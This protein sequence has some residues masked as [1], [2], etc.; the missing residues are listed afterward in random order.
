MIFDKN[1]IF[2]KGIAILTVV[3]ITFEIVFPT[4][5]FSQS[6]PT[7][8]ESTGYNHSSGGENVD[9]FTGDFNYSIPVMDIE[10][11]PLILSYNS[12]VT[13]NQES[14]W[15]GYGW[16]LN[17][18]SIARQMRGV[19]DEFNGDDKI[20]REFTRKPSKIDG[21]KGGVE[22]SAG[23]SV[24][25]PGLPL[26]AQGSIGLSFLKGRYYNNYKGSGKTYDFG[27][28]PNIGMGI[29]LQAGAIPLHVGA[30]VGVGL[31]FSFDTQNGIGVNPSFSFGV[32]GSASIFSAG[33][34]G[35]S[36]SNINTREGQKAKT[37]YSSVTLGILGFSRTRTSSSIKTFG[38][39]TYVPR[40]NFDS[41]GV[42]QVSRKGG[43]LYV[44]AT[45]F[46]VGASA[47]IN[48]IKE[49]YNSQTQSVE[50]SKEIPV[51]GYNNLE[52][53]E[54]DPEGILDFN[55]E[56]ERIFSEKMQTLPFSNITYDL[57]QINTPGVSAMF[58]A[59]R[60]DV[61][62]LSNATVT[63]KSISSSK[64]SSKSF[65]VWVKKVEGN[66]FGIG[67][68]KSGDWEN[69]NGVDPLNFEQNNQILG[70]EKFHFK[71]VGEKTPT[72][73][74]LFNAYGGSNPIFLDMDYD[75][76]NKILN[77]SDTIK[78]P[79]GQNLPPF[80][81]TV[82]QKTEREIRATAINY[83]HNYEL[84]YMNASEIRNY[85]LYEE[86]SNGLVGY[87]VLNDDYRKDH[88]LGKME[89]STP[90]GSV[91]GYGIPAYNLSESEVS[92]NV[93]PGIGGVNSNTG[94][95]NYQHQG[96]ADNSLLNE[97][98]RDHYYDKTTTPAY[99]YSYLLTDIKSSDY[100][101][102]NDDGF[103]PDDI[104]SYVKFNYSR[105]YG[106]TVPFKWRFPVS[107]K[108]TSV[109]GYPQ[110]NFHTGFE[111]DELDDKG[112]YSY[113]EK[114]IWYPNSIETKNYIIEF[115]L[116]DRE[117]AYP[118][119]GKNGELDLNKASKLLR[120]IVLYSREDRLKNGVNATPIKT[121]E[122]EYDYSLCKNNPSNKNIGNSYESSGKLTLKSIRFTSGDSK[123]TAQSPYVFTYENKNPDFNYLDVDR[124]SNY[125]QNDIQKPNLNFPYSIQNQSQADDNIKAWKLKRIVYPT[126][127]GMEVDY[128]ADTY[129]NIQDKG[130]MRHYDMVGVSNFGDLIDRLYNSPGDNYNTSGLGLNLSQ[131]FR[132]PTKKKIPNNV[133][134]FKL[135]EPIVSASRFSANI[136]LRN[137]YFTY[138]EN[139]QFHEMDELYYRTKVSIQQDDLK[140][141]FIPGFAG[142][143]SEVTKTNEHKENYRRHKSDINNYTSNSFSSLDGIGVVGGDNGTYY[144]GYIVLETVGVKD[145]IE[146]K[147]FVNK[148]YQVNP[149]QKNAWNFVR[150]NMPWHIYAKCEDSNGNP[151]IE[152]CD[153]GLGADWKT[154]FTGKINKVLN[155]NEYCLDF[156]PLLSTIRLMD[157][158]GYKYGGNGRIKSITYFDSWNQI[159]G[160]LN[161]ASYTLEYDYKDHLYSVNGVDRFTSG[162]AAYEPI[163]GGDENIYFQPSY[164]DI[165]NR[166]KPDERHYQI[167]PLGESVFPAPTVGYS[168][169]TVKFKDLANLTRNSTG[170]SRYNY[171]TYRNFPV[172]VKKSKLEIYDPGLE[173]DV[174]FTQKVFGVSQGFVVELNDMH[175]KVRNIKV[176]D[177]NDQEVSKTDY[178][179]YNFNDKQKVINEKGEIEEHWLGKEFDIYADKKY[180]VQLNVDMMVTTTKEYALIPIP[181][182]NHSISANVIATGFFA[183]TFQKVINHTAIVKEIK[184]TYLGQKSNQKVVA[185]DKYTG[186]PIVT[187][188]KNEFG[189]D[190]Y[191]V[192]YPSQWRYNS[193]QSKYKNQRF[194][195]LNVTIDAN[196]NLIGT[197]NVEDYYLPGDQ[198]L[199]LDLTNQSQ[200][201][202]FV[203]SVNIAN[204]TVELMNNLG[205][206]ISA[207]SS[208]LLVQVL[209]SAYKNRL[210]ESM[211]S[212]YTKNDPVSN[213][214]SNLT[215]D[216]A[217]VIQ[218]SSVEY[219]ENN[220]RITEDEFGCTGINNANFNCAEDLSNPFKL[221]IIGNWR[222]AKMFAYQSERVNG[223]AVNY[224]NIRND[225]FLTNFIPFY[226]YGN[227]NWNTIVE[228]DHPNF[229]STTNFQNWN[230][231]N[232]VTQFD[233]FGKTIESRSQIGIYSSVLYGYNNNFK[234]V[235]I[236]KASN[237]KV[238]QIAFDGFEDYFYLNGEVNCNTTGHFDYKDVVN[239]SDITTEDRHTGNFSLKVNPNS[240]F[241]TSR[242][243]NE[244]ENSINYEL[245]HKF[246]PTEGRYTLGVWVKQK[247]SPQLTDYPD[248]RVVIDVLGVSGSVTLS[249][250][251]TPSGNIVE[252]WQRIE[253]TFDIPPNTSKDIN[254]IRV[255]LENKANKV[256]YF[257]DLRMHPF[258]SNMQ[259]MVYDATLLL[260]LASLD[261]YNYATYYMYDENLKQVRVRQETERGI[262]TVVETN[263]GVKK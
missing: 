196:S 15:V 216:P 173:K 30:S 29:G 229:I 237:A 178:T 100:V 182:V 245:E 185:F 28:S 96:N 248:A 257:D 219:I 170:S 147:Q 74:E 81:P 118:V 50:N 155:N 4:I 206:P 234:S 41:F 7:Q 150:L 220:A 2:F 260:P 139:G 44:G 113:G 75:E 134:Y 67:V 197:A 120:K 126:G 138:F 210:N 177:A 131:Q 183:A 68:S 21:T 209:K 125:K 240:S 142:I 228:S 186:N 85:N 152:D 84:D 79:S 160:E 94:L 101:D 76:N 174:V 108:P 103:T 251:L 16:S 238:T 154:I 262:Y 98:G 158:R 171:Y 140:Q 179:Y 25:I 157:S 230:L 90:S 156:N 241:S 249:T 63:S 32:N 208:L 69:Q 20:T 51:Y 233:R 86:N 110:A 189:D 166:L 198:L 255:T 164:F 112:F 259:T 27:I 242:K 91:Y 88:H 214:Y 65:G 23:A 169:V 9:N 121:V 168:M 26:S 124:W 45:V 239:T 204:N 117:D 59:Y 105:V 188:S 5:V 10:G 181:Q 258:I 244:N 143:V 224:T 175:G 135:D 217:Q 116:E 92:F 231:I 14:S 132:H 99:A 8:T 47:T 36:T 107:E 253:G 109:S 52:Q 254:C 151:S 114:E 190:D 261:A 17:P 194:G 13:M 34:N 227:G 93:E 60:N 18:G 212:F 223:N 215:I 172:V 161:D 207:N 176:I 153:Y 102:K 78:N 46:G 12:N 165:N 82:N 72:N 256:M 37:Y 80:L 148:G 56:K 263:S 162:V 43:G 128:E 192:S 122:F 83:F 211:A 187:T 250:I 73:E 205:N 71:I 222:P 146:D 42:A 163:N 236:A 35:G 184:T 111:T 49:K 133:V 33:Y 141:E 226:A 1:K 167:D 87:T 145:E 137:K 3:S 77:T 243:F 97:K 38:T 104:G 191:M 61:G 200:E 48:G 202:A 159:S 39:Q 6:G 129:G 136:Q 11:F 123:I 221:G 24:P 106:G 232:Q 130:V 144:Y 180:V 62:T 55:R 31:G 203:K 115:Y 53:G 119:K 193:L 252:G 235:P 213:S 218:S 246:S 247:D 22:L 127:G 89:V 40:L 54:D 195:E 201:I 66:G 58:R 64:L 19:P 199:L 95:V 57:Y 70:Y 225:G 149:M